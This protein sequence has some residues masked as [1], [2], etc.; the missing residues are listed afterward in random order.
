[1]KC[2]LVYD[3]HGWEFAIKPETEMEECALQ[4][5]AT[6]PTDQVIVR[7]TPLGI[8]RRSGKNEDKH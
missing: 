2:E 6:R 8:F 4:Y 3:E 7:S 5:L 1:M